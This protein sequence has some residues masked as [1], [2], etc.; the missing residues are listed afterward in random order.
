MSWYEEPPC[1]IT[2]DHFWHGGVCSSCGERL[3]CA[4]GQFVKVEELDFHIGMTCPTAR[5]APEWTPEDG[6]YAVP[7]QSGE[8]G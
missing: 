8:Q 1:S 7:A 3:R 6:D 5:N 2:G 4:C